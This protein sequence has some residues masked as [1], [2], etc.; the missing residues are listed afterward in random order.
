MGFSEPP[1]DGTA[2]VVSPVVGRTTTGGNTPVEPTMLS[3]AVE[4][5]EVGFSE[6]PDEGTALLGVVVVVSPVDGKTTTG[7]TMPVEATSGITGL[8]DGM[9]SD[10]DVSGS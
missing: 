8:L 6:P 4:V 7:G 2:V 5:S 10:V 3:G 1:V 9:P